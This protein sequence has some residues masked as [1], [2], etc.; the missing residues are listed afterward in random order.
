MTKEEFEKLKPGDKVKIVR[1]RVSGMNNMGEMDKWL[2]KIMTVKERTVGG[3][4]HMIEDRHEHYGSGWYWGKDMIECKVTK[5]ENTIHI[6]RRG[7]KTIAKCDKKVGIAKCSTEDE[8]D[9]AKGAIIAVARL[10]GYGVV[11]DEAGKVTLAN[12]ERRHLEKIAKS[13][14]KKILRRIY[15]TYRT[16]P[17]D[18][19]IDKLAEGVF[20]KPLKETAKERVYKELAEL[21]ERTDKLS[22]ALLPLADKIGTDTEAYNLLSRQLDVMRIY[23]EILKRRLAIWKD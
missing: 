23:A 15:R 20:G 5:A 17:S 22:H 14:A 13:A 18:A 21:D 11:S 10:Y 12:E 6:L 16:N 8:Y 19:A 2:G 3:N 4:I 1:K 7:N 9:E